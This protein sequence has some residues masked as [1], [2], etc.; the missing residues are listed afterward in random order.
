VCAV[1][2][3]HCTVVCR[4]ASQHVQ[5]RRLL[6]GVQQLK[7]RDEGLRMDRTAPAQP[8]SPLCLSMEL[9]AL[10]FEAQA[11]AAERSASLAADASCQ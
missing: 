8:T 11:A 7:Q 5:L 2:H 4:T 6:A 10:T 1:T 9:N 3:E